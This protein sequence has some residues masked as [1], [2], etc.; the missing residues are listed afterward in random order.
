[1]FSSGDNGAKGAWPVHPTLAMTQLIRLAA[2]APECNAHGSPRTHHWTG[3][4]LLGPGVGAVLAAGW[5]LQESAAGWGEPGRA[6]WYKDRAR[7]MSKGI[8]AQTEGKSGK[9]HFLKINK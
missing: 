4:F 8:K 2:A 5:N 1:M 7:E 3:K 6:W 9:I